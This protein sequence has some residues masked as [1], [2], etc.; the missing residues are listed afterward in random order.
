MSKLPRRM[1]AR[2][3]VDQ[4]LKNKPSKQIAKEIAAVAAEAGQVLDPE[5]LLGDIAWELERRKELV[6][7]KVSSAHELSPDLRAELSSQLKNST[8]AKEVLLE[9]TTDRSLI[10]GLRVETANRV[11]DNTVS[12]KL[13]QLRETN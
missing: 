1:L 11:W 8:G 4:L 9:E 2:Y 3:A 10:G 5:F 6:V 7:G 12:R 13:S